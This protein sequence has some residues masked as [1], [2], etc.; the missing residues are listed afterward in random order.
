MIANQLLGVLMCRLSQIVHYKKNVEYKKRP[1]QHAVLIAKRYIEEK[2]Q[3]DISLK[4]L[5]KLTHINSYH[6]SHLF[7][8]ETG[9]SPIQHLISYR[10][11][12]SKQYLITTDKSIGEIAELVGYQSETYFHNIF[13]K[14]TG[15]PPGRYRS[16]SQ[17]QF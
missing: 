5:A 7:K 6:F 3:T 11:E 15:M 8:K 14:V 2:Y 13:K 12:V 10:V 16:E 9:L 4:T 1:S 17:R